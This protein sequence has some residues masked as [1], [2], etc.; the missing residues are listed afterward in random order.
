MRLFI[1]LEDGQPKTWPLIGANVRYLAPEGVGFPSGADAYEEVDLSEFGFETFAEADQPAFDPLTH[2]IAETAPIKV[3]GVWT[4]QWEVVALT[5]TEAQAATQAAQTS[6]M[7]AV[8]VAT[9][10]RLDAF[11]RTRNYDSIL[12]ACSYAMSTNAKFAA[13]GAY[14][15]K[16]RD[17]TWATL[18]AVLAQVQA[19]TRPMPSGY[20]DIEPDLP[21]LSWPA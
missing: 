5:N 13:E 3:H 14:C 1:Q 18:Y 6:L 15:M 20:A 19:G 8:T 17:D 10:A 11:A 21:A 4:R 16:A 2:K 9:Q 7:A 12:S